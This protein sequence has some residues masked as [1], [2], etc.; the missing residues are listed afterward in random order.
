MLK[1]NR[2]TLILTSIIILLPILVGIVLWNKL[3]DTMATHFG[4]DNEANGFSSKFLVF[5]D[6]HLFYWQFIYLAQ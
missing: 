5:L 2:K 1:K 3:P 4:I 6:Y